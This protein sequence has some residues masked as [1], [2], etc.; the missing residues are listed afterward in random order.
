V[1]KVK[2]IP[3]KKV[4]LLKGEAKRV[5]FL[6]PGEI[7][8]LLSNCADHLKPI[9]TV[10]L[11]TGMRKSELLNLKWEQVNLEQGIISLLD[12]K[13]HERRDIPM[14]ETAKGTM[15]GIERKGE[16]VFSN[17]DGQTFANVRNSFDT[18]V[19][20]SG[21]TDF[22]F[23]MTFGIPSLPTWLWRGLIS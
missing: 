3:V 11:H 1:R 12:T 6:L 17:G 20:K 7:Q 2:A 9:V 13:N 16:H 22:R 14:N 19:R 15:Q 23:S 10:A 18:P 4:K 8:R 5:R 21:I